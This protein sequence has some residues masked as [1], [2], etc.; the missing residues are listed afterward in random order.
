LIQNLPQPTQTVDFDYK[1]MSNVTTQAQK[2]ASHSQ[3]N[4]IIF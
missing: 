3:Y 1:L 2:L 4:S